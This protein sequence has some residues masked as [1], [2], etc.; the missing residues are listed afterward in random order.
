M[1]AV[2]ADHD[3]AVVPLAVGEPQPDAV[4]GLVKAGAATVEMQAAWRQCIERL[5]Q[6]AVK[7]AAMH[8]PVGRAIDGAR[9]GAEVEQL[10]GPPSAEQPDFLARRLTGNHLHLLLEAERDQD[11]GAVGAELDSGAEFAQLGRLLEDLDVDP[12][13]SSDNP[14]TSPPIPAPATRTFGGLRCALTRM[15]AVTCA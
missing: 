14:A 12:A 11:A 2:G 3:L 6:H 1:D 4:A 5:D 9:G 15:P 7:I 10:P 8:H 13:C